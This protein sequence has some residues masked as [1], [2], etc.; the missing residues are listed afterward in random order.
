MVKLFK[1]NKEK[2]NS[3]ID[4]ACTYLHSIVLYI[5]TYILR[6]IFL[7][8]LIFS[9][10]YLNHFYLAPSLAKLTQFLNSKLF[11]S[12]SPKMKYQPT[13]FINISRG[14]KIN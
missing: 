2:L 3:Y 11:F 6:E 7:S 4:K 14:E 8:L 13:F 9:C 1:Y 12:I 10:I 5:G